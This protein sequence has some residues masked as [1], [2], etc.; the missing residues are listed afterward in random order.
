MAKHTWTTGETITAALMNDLE[1][2]AETGANGAMTGA[3]AAVEAIAEP[4]TADA[5]TIAA[6]VNEIITQL[7]ARGVTL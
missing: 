4:T 1:G 3:A 7:K 6:K 5:A 2:R